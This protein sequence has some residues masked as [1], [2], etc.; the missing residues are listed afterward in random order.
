MVE[1]KIDEN[2]SKVLDEDPT[3]GVLR[4]TYNARD[5]AKS[6]WFIS[7]PTYAN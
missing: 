6:Q 3:D 5:S 2:A 4:I 1:I 7:D